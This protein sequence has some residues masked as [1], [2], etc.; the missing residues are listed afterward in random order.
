MSSSEPST[1]I[2]D[3]AS[4]VESPPRSGKTKIKCGLCGA[5]FVHKTNRFRLH[6]SCRGGD[7]KPCPNAPKDVQILFQA[8]LD[9]NR[10]PSTPSKPSASGSGTQMTSTKDAEEEARLKALEE[11]QF[12]LALKRS[13]EDVSKLQRYSSQRQHD[14]EAGSSYSSSTTNKKKKK[15]NKL[16]FLTR[17]GEFYRALGTTYNSSHKTSLKNLV[18]SVEEHEGKISSPSDSE[19]VNQFV[20][21]KIDSSSDGSDDNTAGTGRHS[22]YRGY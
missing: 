11:E 7:A 12:Q 17:L 21:E 18:E 19:E 16:K 8:L 6:L 13:M 4:L 2:W 5:K 15:S 1:N 14:V 10:K 3:Y 22:S 20:Y 9:S